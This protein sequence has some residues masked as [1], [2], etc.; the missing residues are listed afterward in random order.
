MLLTF[1]FAPTA[2]LFQGL[3]EAL[4]VSGI[5]T[6]TKSPSQSHL[7]TQLQLISGSGTSQKQRLKSPCC[8]NSDKTPVHAQ[9]MLE[10]VSL[11]KSTM[12]WMAPR[13]M[14]CR[15]SAMIMMSKLRSN[16]LAILPR[17]ETFLKVSRYKLQ[18]CQSL[19]SL[20]KSTILEMMVLIK[21]WNSAKINVSE[22]V[23]SEAA[24]II[25]PSYCVLRKSTK[26]LHC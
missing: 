19:V 13:P 5:H 14:K 4:V 16:K 26:P 8:N 1:K 21:G 10:S 3:L 24:P 22:I 25:W 20:A 2:E 9:W 17:W 23:A 6:L 11:S 7:C 12:T 15:S 18:N